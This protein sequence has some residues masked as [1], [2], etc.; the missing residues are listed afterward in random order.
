LKADCTLTP[1]LSTSPV[2]RLFDFLKHGL[3]KGH[4][5]LDADTSHQHK[6]IKRH[7]FTGNSPPHTTHGNVNVQ[8]DQYDTIDGGIDHGQEG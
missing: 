2:V 7:S 3:N 8:I 4:F 1:E 5:S 6:L